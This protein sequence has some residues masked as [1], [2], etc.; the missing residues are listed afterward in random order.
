MVAAAGFRLVCLCLTSSS[1]KGVRAVQRS[2]FTLASSKC[3]SNSVLGRRDMTS[4]DNSNSVGLSDIGAATNDEDNADPAEGKSWRALLEVSSN[5]SR[6]IRGANFIQLATVDPKTNEPRCRTVVFRGFLTLPKGHTSTIVCDGMSCVMK[7]ITDYRSQKVSQVMDHPSKAA[8]MVW[9]FQKSSEQYRISGELLFVGSGQFDLDGDR[10]LCIARK[11][12]WGNLS[13]SSREAF[14]SKLVPGESYSDKPDEVPAGGRD[15]SGRLLPP[16]DNFLLMLLLPKS[17]DY[18]R[19]TNM[20][21][22]GD[23][24]SPNGEW[25]SARLN[26]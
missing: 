16:P 20:Y 2:A 8:E 25:S 11:E 22:Q 6:K 1:L 15:E 13:D 26:P 12:M 23:E 4:Q 7:M 14:F 19:L 18:I 17:V 24:R 3:L 10:D 5:R 21:K 9:W